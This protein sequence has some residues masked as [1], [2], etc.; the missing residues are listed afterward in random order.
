MSRFAGDASF[1]I[2]RS[3]ANLSPRLIHYQAI[4]LSCRGFPISL[5]DTGP[6]DNADAYLSTR[7]DSWYYRLGRRR[8]RE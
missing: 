8:E 5:R 4:G 1:E 3:Q 7:L 6:I 2:D